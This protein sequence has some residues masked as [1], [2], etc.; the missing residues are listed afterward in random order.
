ML[1][2]GAT[3]YLF[4]DPAMA[5]RVC[6]ELE[7]KPIWLSKPKA[8]YGFNGKRALDVTHTIYPTMTVQDHRETVTSMLVT[9]LD[10]HQI[11]LEKLWIKKHGAIL[12][13]K[14]NQLSFWLGHYQHTKPHAKP[15]HAQKLHEEL[16]AKAPHREKSCVELSPGEKQH[17]QEPHTKELHAGIPVKILKQ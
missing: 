4:V 1:D 15:S 7:I 10:Q 6:D 2:T 3:G 14:N 9:K 12:D 11:I 8:I 5:C 17:T 13:M 16:N